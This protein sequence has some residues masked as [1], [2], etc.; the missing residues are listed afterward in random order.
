MVIYVR[1][2]ICAHHLG[3]VSE[4][5]ICHIRHSLYGLK[6]APRAW[7]QHFTSLVIATGFSASAHDSALYIHV[8][9]H[10]RT[11]LLRYVDD[12]IIIVDDPNYIAFVKARLS[13]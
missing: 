11:L 1:M 10:C 13:D 3:I 5:M 9:L 2:F 4:G 8:S 12:M 6:Q 7:F